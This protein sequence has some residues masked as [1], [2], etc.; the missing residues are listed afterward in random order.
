MTSQSA[1]KCQRD[2]AG[3]ASRSLAALRLWSEARQAARYDNSIFI[4]IPKNA[5]TSVHEMLRNWGLVKLTT[6]RS[7]RL[8]FRNSGRVTFG[9]M[10]IQSLVD[11]GMVSPE[12]IERAFKFALV[13]D[14]YA[15]A[16]SLYRF[17]SHVNILQNWHEQPS[18]RQFLELIARGYYD[19]IG[20]YNYK[21]LSQCNPQITWLRDVWPDK[22]YRVED[23]D[24]F[25]ADLC[26]RW[27]V[28]R[29][30]I[31][32]LNKSKNRKDVQLTRSEK[33]LI[34]HIYAEDFETFGYPMR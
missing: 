23:I 6:T 7:V 26:E 22:I 19:R 1:P 28:P 16:V 15:R 29:M 11:L 4:W 13:R 27:D 10:A 14:P 8:C 25:V 3:Y 32:H 20:P 18:F 33:S 2:P 30:S 17:L 12:F 21:G 24:Q 9:H 31:P 34:E 5:G